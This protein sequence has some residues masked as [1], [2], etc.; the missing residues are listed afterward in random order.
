VILVS[1]MTVITASAQTQTP[2]L[3]TIVQRIEQA[4]VAIHDSTRPYQVT[5]QYLFYEGSDKPNADSSV[6]A[7]VSYYPPDSKQFEIVKASG[8]GRGEHVVKKVLEHETEMAGD[9]RRTAITGE[10]YNFKFVGEETLNGRRC[11]VL[12]LEPRRKAK[13]LIEGK[14]WVDATNYRVLQIQ[15]EPAKSPSFWIKKLDVTLYFSEVDG[16]WLQTAIRA[17]ADVRVFGRNVLS[18][19][20]LTYRVGTQSAMKRSQRHPETT[21]ATYVR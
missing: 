16:M 21:I 18:E 7:D 5:R 19:R 9:W 11:F 10:N 12:G 6:T 13:E 2:D 8:S 17:V 15:G 20:D 4:Q 1:M 3:A 14:A